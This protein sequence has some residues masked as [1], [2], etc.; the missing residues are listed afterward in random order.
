MLF[1]SIG[2]VERCNGVYCV[3]VQPI[4][5]LVFDIHHYCPVSYAAYHVH[6]SLI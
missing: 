4:L 5:K 6:T 2:D 1:F 3:G